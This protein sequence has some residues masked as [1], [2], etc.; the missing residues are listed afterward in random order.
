MVISIS[1]YLGV[2]HVLALI[3]PVIS[4]LWQIYILYSF[5]SIKDLIVHGNGVY[6]IL[7][8][9]NLELAREYVGMIVGRDT[10]QLSSD[11][12]A[13]ATVESLSENSSDG[14]IA[15]IFFAIICGPV[16]ITIY[17]TINTMDSMIGYKNEKY[18]RF[19]F[20][21]AKTDDLVNFIPARITLFFILL[22]KIFSIR[23]WKL[24]LENSRN[25]L[26]PN[27]GYC[28][29]A[30]AALL[31]VRMGG[32]A[33]YRGIAVNRPTINKNGGSLTPDHIRKTIDVIK[34]FTLFIFCLIILMVLLL[35]TL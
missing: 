31:N 28:E 5:L 26:S 17:K 7:K 11:E 8:Q 9:G 1:A 34:L 33:F 14:I 35:H 22:S 10:Y 2:N 27:S 18:L 15:P 13:Q 25:H 16:G 12:I 20:V 24:A 19:G 21:A 3:H 4:Y 30:I 32:T 23:V 29:A 6:R